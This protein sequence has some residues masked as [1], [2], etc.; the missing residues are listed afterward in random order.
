MNLPESTDKGL[1][2]FHPAVSTWFRSTFPS[3]TNAQAQAWPLI[4]Q[5]RSTLIAAPTGSGKTLTAFLAVLDDLV[6]Q[7]LA[8]GGELPDQTLAAGNPHRCAHRRHPA[9]RPRPDAQTR[10][11]YPGNH[12]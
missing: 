8:N 4:R 1:H 2:G 11:A 12:S 6:H 10:T 5:R 9:K 3:A 7:G